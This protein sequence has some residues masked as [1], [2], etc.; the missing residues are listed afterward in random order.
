[1][2]VTGIFFTEVEMENLTVSFRLTKRE[3][4]ELERLA[5][6]KKL[7]RQQ[8]AR[9]IFQDALRR[10]RVRTQIHIEMERRRATPE[11]K[12][13]FEGI[14]KFRAKVKKVPLS[15]LDADIAEAIQAVRKQTRK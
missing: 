3:A 6:T 8:A 4:L 14:A 12:A 11:W 7:K 1:M 15:E 10:E 13:A 5:I 9:K 2:R